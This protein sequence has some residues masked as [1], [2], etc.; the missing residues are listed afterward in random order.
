[1]I[2]LLAGAGAAFSF[3]N[4]L[5]AKSTIDHPVVV[6]IE[7][8]SGVEEIA[9]Q[10]EDQGIVRSAWV[11]K[12]YSV[13]SG[14]YKQL[15]S[16]RFRFEPGVTT[17]AVVQELAAGN[18]DMEVQV[19]LLEGWTIDQ[20]DDYLSS[21]VGLFAVGTFAAAAGVT[22]S[23]T[24][25]PNQTYAFFKSK[26]STVNLEGYLF[27]DTYRLFVDAQPKD[28][29]KKMLDNFEQ[30]VTPEVQAQFEAQGLSIHQ[31]VT[32]ASL[33]EKEAQ[34]LEDKRLVAGILF[35]RLGYGMPLQLDTSVMYATGTAG[36]DLTAVDLKFDSPYN[37]YVYT[38]LPIGPISNPGLDAL[39]AV[40]QPTT[41]DYLY[42]ITDPQGT[43][44]YSNTYEEHLTKKYQLYPWP[45]K[46]NQFWSSRWVVR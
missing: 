33:L 36:A 40:A 6:D 42:F 46:L 45:K 30:Q 1:M 20:M 38:G 41:T 3:F 7:A 31:A 11:F 39:Q 2:L 15:P 24:L 10:L 21:D 14:T 18:T 43:V 32:M 44:Y 35:N 25:L 8:G 26:P 29:I 13:V 28:L 19:T 9:Q 37:T 5:Q 34:T 16:G 17:R 4:A 23:R 27:P 12:V 22:D